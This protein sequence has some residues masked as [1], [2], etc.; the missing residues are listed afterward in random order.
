[1]K[2]YMHK[3]SLDSCVLVHS[4]R[5]TSPEYVTLDMEWFNLGYGGKPWSLGQCQTI[6]LSK[7]A[8]LEEWVD[9]S[10]K[11]KTPRKKP[12]LPE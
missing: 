9:I 7:S 8:L 10:R 5:A 6:H 11:V 3:N 2:F 1:M 12:G 4:V